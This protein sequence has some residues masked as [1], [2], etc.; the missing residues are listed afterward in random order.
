MNR[1]V[2]TAELIAH[3]RRLAREL[4]N[5]AIREA[6]LAVV[7]A[8]SKLLTTRE[9]KQSTRTRPAATGLLH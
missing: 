5:A 1:P 8:F 9:T 6:M 4:R 7:R 2:I 3:H